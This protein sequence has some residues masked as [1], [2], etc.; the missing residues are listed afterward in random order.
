MK[1]IITAISFFVLTFMCH[2][3]MTDDVELANPRPV[4]KGFGFGLD[5]AVSPEPKIENY[6]NPPFSVKKPLHVDFLPSI[7]YNFYNGSAVGLMVGLGQA[8]SD[9]Y[10]DFHDQTE[11]F[12]SISTELGLFYKYRL[13][14]FN[15]RL[16]GYIQ[17]LVRFRT[18]GQLTTIRESGGQVGQFLTGGQTIESIDLN[19]RLSLSYKIIRK[20]EV[21]LFVS[22]DVISKELV[23]GMNAFIQPSDKWVFK[24]DYIYTGLSLAYRLK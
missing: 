19:L 6:T 14:Y 2:A 17:P 23:K 5:Y 24:K 8:K 3:Q 16:S 11:Y 22:N 18:V 9:R 1:R 15:S 4:Y 12:A 10:N 7:S 13:I 21:G 20:L